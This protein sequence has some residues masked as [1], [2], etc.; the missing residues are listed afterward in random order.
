MADYRMSLPP[1]MTATGT[2]I[3][4]DHGA[5]VATT[6]DAFLGGRLAILQPAT[7]YRA[8]LDAVLLAAAAP[9]VAGT[10]ATVLDAGSGVGTVG[11]CLAA[12]IP[13]ARLTLVEVSPVLAALARRNAERNQMSDRVTV[14]QADICES[15]TSPTISGLIPESFEHVLANP[16]YLNA[17]RARLPAD[18]IKAV[19]NAMPGD[20]LDRWLRFLARMAAPGGTLTMI[21]RADALAAVLAALNGRFGAVQVLP[22]HPRPNAPAH[23]IIVTARKGSRAPMSIRPALVLHASGTGS[24][25][26]PEIAAIMREALPLARSEP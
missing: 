12:R 25:F 7:G 8:G 22:I 3:D 18:P 11:L 23:R 13:G 17:S 21:H 16:P 2:I 15:A 6:D 4:T 10:S 14:I 24:A 5:F 26:V 20:H 9:V 1:D 19:A